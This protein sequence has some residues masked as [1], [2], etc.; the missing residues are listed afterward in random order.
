[1]NECC[2]DLENR[3]PVEKVSEDLSL[4]RCVVCGA[5][6]FELDIDEGDLVGEVV[7]L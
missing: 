6:H 1:M 3:G 4:T 2:K 7:S 5:R